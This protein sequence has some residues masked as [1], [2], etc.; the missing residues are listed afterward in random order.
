MSTSA[1]TEFFTTAAR[2]LQAAGAPL[3]VAASILGVEHFHGGYG[4]ARLAHE[5]ALLA[6]PSPTRI[7]RAA[8]FHELVAQ[9][10]EWG[11]RDDTIVVPRMRTQLIAARTV[12]EALAELALAPDAPTYAEIAGPREEN[13]PDMARLLAGGLRVL[14]VS[15]PDY[16]H[17]YENGALLPGPDT[18]LAGPTFIEWLTFGQSRAA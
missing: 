13:L 14:E 9:L 2:N 18:T 11:R 1:S 5:R 4:A 16:G 12:A 3:I 15:D 10:V 8:Q 6:G 17:L 7:L